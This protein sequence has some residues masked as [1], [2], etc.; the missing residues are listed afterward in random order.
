MLLLAACVMAKRIELHEGAR[1]DFDESFDWYAER[2]ADAA[3][4]FVAEFE[5]AVERIPIET[6]RF[7]HAAADCQYVALRHYPYRVVFR[8]EAARIVIVA[9]AHAKR[10]HNFW[11]NRR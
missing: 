8:N 4:G 6:Q 9:V 3:L 10:R 5:A 7:P 1:Q 11:R 2:S